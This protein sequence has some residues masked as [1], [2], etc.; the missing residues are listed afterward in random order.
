MQTPDRINIRVYKRLPIGTILIWNTQSLND[1]QRLNFRVQVRRMT[2][3][4]WIVPPMEAPDVTKMNSVLDG[5]TDTV[6]IKHEGSIGEET[7]FIAKI[8]YG[9]ID[10]REASIKV[11]GRS[12]NT[13]YVKPVRTAS[14]VYALPVD[15]ANLPLVKTE[16]GVMALPVVIVGD[17]RGGTPL[18]PQSLIK[19]AA[20]KD[21][22]N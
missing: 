16:H 17:Y 20:P 11:A 4:H 6:M 1:E 8:T 9:K 14:G 22:D 12:S 13:P 2:D 18:P 15:L 19:E 21:D 5:Q 3:S 10:L 7:P